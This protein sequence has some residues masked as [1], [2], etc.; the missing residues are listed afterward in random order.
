MLR[1]IDYA[2]LDDDTKAY[3]RAVRNGNGVG[4]PGVFH[5]MSSGMPVVA[6]LAGLAVIPLFVWAGYSSNKPAW[7][8]AMIQT[9]G[10]VLGGWMILYAIRRW[11]ASAD[12]YAG[13]FYYFDPLHVFVG[14]GEQLQYAHIREEM[15]AEP[16]GSSGLRFEDEVSAF[17]L[18]LPNRAIALYAA[19]YYDA[20]GHLSED[21][22][23]RWSKLN[24]AELGAVAKYMV[25]N[26]R[27]PAS[28]DDV[29]L[30]I[31]DIPDEVRPRR[32]GGFGPLRYLLILAIGAGVFFAFN[33]TNGP[34]QDEANFAAAKDGGPTK[35]RDYL[36]N[37]DNTKHR[38]E[39]EK[40]L[41]QKYDAP[42]AKVKA[43]GTDPQIRDGFAELLDTLRGP[44]TPA[45]SV[46]V[47]DTNPVAM[48]SWAE[49]LRTRFADG[50]GTAVG[51][52]FIVFVKAP[53]GKPGLIDLK[54]STADE[55]VVKWTLELRRKPDDATPYLSIPRTINIAGGNPNG[56]LFSPS[57][58]VYQDVMKRLVGTAPAAPPPLPPDEDW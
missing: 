36:L 35:L 57:E 46:S 54:Y 49:S 45:V 52:E 4:S 39:A 17:Q 7:A 9:A 23:G 43:E 14:Q 3:L 41:A 31:E 15:S 42:I 6:F 47:A 16:V 51:K 19:N 33:S 8:N 2:Q 1:T 26:E 13:Q 38:D 12:K 24:S 34:I 48:A 44:E 58:A 27:P 32:G 21:E 5:P 56:I 37:P 11:T 10:V 53:D 22:E 25:R 30:N 18:N 50:I 55:N 28:L 29:D 40:L 20:L